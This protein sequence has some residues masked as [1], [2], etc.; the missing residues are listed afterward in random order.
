M[1]AHIAAAVGATGAVLDRLR[2]APRRDVVAIEGTGSFGAGLTTAL[3][4]R[5][6]RIVEVNR[7]QRPARR[8][9]VKS[10][11]I[12]AVRAARRR[13]PVWAKASG[14]KRVVL[15][16]YARNRP[17][18]DALFLQAFAALNNSPEARAFYDRQR[19]RGATHDQALRTLANRLAG[20]PC[21][22]NR[23]RARS[24]RDHR[25]A[26]PEQRGSE[27]HRLRSHPGGVAGA[28]GRVAV[29][30]RGGCHR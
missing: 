12:D 6:E 29:A 14:T 26:R 9:G 19:A 15:A 10:D 18:G 25:V 7:P 2:A 11:D 13:S 17:L 16:R 24:E 3:L 4:A 5:C 21:E 8:G 30:R 23:R 22:T 27:T 20:I 1:C 28:S